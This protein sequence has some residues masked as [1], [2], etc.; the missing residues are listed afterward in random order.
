MHLL[1]AA[2]VAA[3]QPAAPGPAPAPAVQARS[4]EQAELERLNVEW[5]RSYVTR[6]GSV[7]DR[8]LAD[9]FIATYANGNRRTK[10]DVIASATSQASRI[11]AADTDKV[12]VH[13]SGDVAVVTAH[14]VLRLRAEDG[15]ETKVRNAYADVYVRRNGRW[16]AIAAHIVRLPAT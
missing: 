8:I 9:D 5:L 2:A 13:V 11:V 15:T 6:D 1:V 3:A 14:S 7:L 16:R 10:A 4:Q 12:A